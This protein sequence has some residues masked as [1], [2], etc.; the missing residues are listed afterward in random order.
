MGI[1]RAR[2]E[3]LALARR[4]P[5]HP[6]AAAIR[7]I[8]DEQM[9]RNPPVRVTRRKLPKLTPEMAEAIRAEAR[10]RPNASQLEIAN[11]LGTNPGRVSEAMN[12]LI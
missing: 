2:E 7:D 5:A 8:V 10:A 11:L 3:L 12:N 4:Y 9:F 1:P 6:M